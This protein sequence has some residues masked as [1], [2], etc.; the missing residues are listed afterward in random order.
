MKIIEIYSNVLIR[1]HIQ[2]HVP[3]R[4]IRGPLVQTISLHPKTS[5][6]RSKKKNKNGRVGPPSFRRL[7]KLLST[8][9]Y[10]IR[11]CICG[12]SFKVH[13]SMILPGAGGSHPILVPSTHLSKCF[14]WLHNTQFPVDIHASKHMLIS[15]VSTK[16]WTFPAIGVCFL[17]SFLRMTSKCQQPPLWQEINEIHPRGIPI[18]KEH[19][20]QSLVHRGNTCSQISILPL[21]TKL[22]RFMTF[23]CLHCL[24]RTLTALDAQGNFAKYIQGITSA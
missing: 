17:V 12:S 19:H 8:P 24:G 15:A 22:T 2:D 16:Q 5:R 7:Q 13:K 1:Q 3:P 11:F 23:L 6:I 9:S 4:F 18:S 10:S 14:G 20:G 21:P